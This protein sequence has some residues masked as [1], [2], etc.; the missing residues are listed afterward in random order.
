MPRITPL[1]S[2]KFPVGARILTRVTKRMIGEAPDTLAMTAHSPGLIWS[3]AWMDKFLIGKRS[4]PN[5]LIELVSVRTAMELGCPFCIDLGSYVAHSQHG[6]SAEELRA[7]ARHE[8][9]AF[10][11]EAE[12]VAFDLAV[13]MSATPVTADDALYARLADHYDERQIVELTATVAWENYR[14]RMN[15]SLGM[16]AQGYS[17]PGVCAVPTTEAVMPQAPAATPA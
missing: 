8:D 10:F 6:V 9:S 7:L 11:T 1:P 4:I 5:R 15:V 3:S 14:S 17:E 12:K 13:A 16:T 2:S